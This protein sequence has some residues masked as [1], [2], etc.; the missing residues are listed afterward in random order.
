ME[1]LRCSDTQKVILATFALEGEVDEWWDSPRKLAKEDYLWTWERFQTKFNEKY[2]TELFR[3]EK[4]SQF[5]K[6][7]QG[8]MT[9]AQYEARFAEL[10]RYVLTIVSEERDR[11]RKFRDRLRLGIRLKLYWK[12]MRL[13][14]AI[15]DYHART[16][17]VTLPR[18]S[19]FTIQGSCQYETYEGLRTLKKTESAEITI[20]QIPVVNEFPKVFQDIPGLPPRREV[21]STIDLLPVLFVK[22]KDGSQCLCIDYRRLNQATV[23]NKYPLLHIDDLFDQLKGAK[24]FSKIDLRLGYHQL[25]VREEDIPKI[26]FY[27]RYGHYKFLAMPFRLTNVP[28]VFMDLMNRVFMPYLH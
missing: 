1:P 18:Q 20:D 16:V 13:A 26:A 12:V 4:V 3:D 27:T 22:K 6:L 14:H 17:T 10:S 15:L 7:E 23:K 28:A 5:F 2:F 11:L 24:Y 19:P 9:V 21:D 8:N 25:R